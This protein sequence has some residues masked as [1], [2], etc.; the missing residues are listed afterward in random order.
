M[1]KTIAEKMYTGTVRALLCR[2]SYPI[3]LRIEGRK[4]L[5]P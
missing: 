5:K 3:L 4:V 1:V 2:V